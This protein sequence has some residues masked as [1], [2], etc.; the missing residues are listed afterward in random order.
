[1]AEQNVLFAEEDSSFRMMEMAINGKASPKG[2]EA[3]HYLFGENIDNQLSYLK[4]IPSSVGLPAGFRGV[5]CDDP[6][7]LPLM[8]ADADYLVCERTE[9]SYELMKRGSGRLKLIQKFGT[10]YK[11]IDVKGA[12]SLGISVAYMRL[13]TSISVAEHALALLFA[14]SRNLMFG[15]DIVKDR[16]NAKDGLCS[17]GPPRTK[18]NWG[19]VPNIQLVQGKTLGLV[20]FGEI[21]FELGM[22]AHR[23]GMKIIYYQR[24]QAQ[25]NREELVDAQYMTSIQELVKEADFTVI[26]VPYALPTEKMF[27]LEILSHMKSG[28]FLI[29]VS[30]GGIVDEQALFKVLKEKRI[31]GAALDVYRWEPMPSDSPLLNLNNIIWSPHT[32]GGSDEIL[33]QV[34][35]DVLANIARVSMGEAPKFSASIT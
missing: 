21:G 12:H 20:G 14:L 29:N 5:V 34:N 11:N 6:N 31:R 15:H 3:L 30:R 23:I 28:S 22:I 16:R 10:D 1:M 8:I 27:N 32:A 35:H 26:L 13:K 4:S 25:R 7:K 24:H 18:F 33:L 2:L 19:K 9:I 17:E